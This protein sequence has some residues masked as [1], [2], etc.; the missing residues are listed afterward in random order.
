METLLPISGMQ[1]KKI[2][3]HP[4]FLHKGEAPLHGTTL[5]RLHFAMQASRTVACP[6]AVM[7]GPSA[8]YFHFQC[9]SPGGLHPA[10]NAPFTNRLLSLLGGQGYSVPS[11]N[12]YGV[13]LTQAN[14]RVNM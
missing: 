1:G 5:F 13:I 3:P 11:S 4:C 7:G 6:S 9:A 12:K 8:A 10:A 14:I 2:R